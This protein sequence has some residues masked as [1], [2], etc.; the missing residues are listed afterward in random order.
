MTDAGDILTRIQQRTKEQL[1]PH[2][3]AYP[4]T[5]I[6]IAVRLLPEREIDDAKLEAQRYVTKRKADLTIDPEFFDR[7]VQRQIVWKAVVHREAGEEGKHAPVFPGDNDIRAVD[8]VTLE[9][10]WRLYMENQERCATLR[11]LTEAQIDALAKEVRARPGAA[12]RQ[13]SELEHATLVRLCVSLL[14]HP[15]D[16]ETPSAE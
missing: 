6:P 4:G 14:D 5:E 3:Y 9:G 12:T 7:E 8:T 2:P 1:A 10:L 16:P 13:L 15:P 11:R